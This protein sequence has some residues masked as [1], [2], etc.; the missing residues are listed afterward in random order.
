MVRVEIRNKV[1]E[2][3]G[4]V[5]ES[6]AYMHGA[7]DPDTGHLACHYYSLG[8]AS[9]VV[10]DTTYPAL[11]IGG[12]MY[13]ISGR[14]NGL[15][16]AKSEAHMIAVERDNVSIGDA[17]I[18]A[19]MLSSL[20]NLAREGQATIRMYSIEVVE[21]NR[22]TKAVAAVVNI[23]QTGDYTVI[24]SRCKDTRTREEDSMYY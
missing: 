23:Q 17:T 6:L 21:G 5:L 16:K 13:L 2:I 20:Y 1:P 9:I 3:P 7:V 4:F 8:V 12:C 24:L 11:V 22:A 18:E 14:V 19:Y 10:G 15:D